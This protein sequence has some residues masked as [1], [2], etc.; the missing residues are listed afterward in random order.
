MR[1]QP[2]VNLM[3][4]DQVARGLKYRESTA[5]RQARRGLEG[6]LSDRDLWP[7][8]SAEQKLVVAL[9]EYD[10][11]VDIARLAIASQEGA[12]LVWVSS[13]I[14]LAYSYFKY[15]WFGPAA[16]TLREAHTIVQSLGKIPTPQRYVDAIA[17]HQKN[18]SGLARRGQ[19]V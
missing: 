15:N 12:D 17:Q 18:L 16:N 3:T 1:E 7:G 11:Q 13:R 19:L 2:V 8:H 9:E 14:M 4:L 10:H 5:V 6:L